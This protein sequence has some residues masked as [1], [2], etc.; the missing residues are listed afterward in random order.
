MKFRFR[1][2]TFIVL[3]CLIIVSAGCSFGGDK[4]PQAMEKFDA[5]KN[6]AIKVMYWDDQYFMQKYGNL[7]M[8][9]YPNIEIEVVSTQSMYEEGKPFDPETQYKKFIEEHQPDIIVISGSELERL[10]NEQM[11][12]DLDPVIAQDKFDIENIHPA[13]ID[14]LKMKGGGKLYALAPNFRSE[15][16]YINRDLFNKHGVELPAEPMTWESMFN[17]AGRF[18]TD[19]DKDSRIY[20]Y[21]NREWQSDAYSMIMKTGLSNGLVMQTD[22]KAS[23]NSPAWKTVFEMIINA[24]KSGTVLTSPPPDFSSGPITQENYLMRNKFVAG[25]AAM[26]IGDINLINNLNELGDFKK[27]LKFNWEIINPPKDADSTQKTNFTLGEVFA[28]N[29][30]STN[31]RAAWE[32]IKYVNSDEIA[33]VLSKTP[34]EL[35]SRPAY[36]KLKNGISLEPFYQLSFNSS[37][38]IEFGEY[39]SAQFMIQDDANKLIDEFL[40]DKKTMDQVLEGINTKLQDSL[41]TI[42]MNKEKKE[43]K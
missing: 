36:N 25:K 8:A 43:T 11:L 22:G 38:T 28:V 39:D 26:T 31:Q 7:F 6:A 19:G 34:S 9:K 40:A 2:T 27:D 17:L 21:T 35:W 3:I 5:K 4:S 16:L 23:L 32:F 42:K 12:Y 14:Y 18:P 13:I 33:R 1:T 41:N 15:A 20:G 37:E 30:K 24:V 29:A 10:I